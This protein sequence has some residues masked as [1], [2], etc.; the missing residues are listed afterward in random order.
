MDKLQAVRQW[1]KDHDIPFLR[2]DWG[3]RAETGESDHQTQATDVVGRVPWGRREVLMSSIPGQLWWWEDKK[4]PWL[5]VPH[6]DWEE[7]LETFVRPYLPLLVEA[8]TRV[9]EQWMYDRMTYQEI[10]DVERITREAV[11]RR[12][13]RGLQDLTRVIA[14]DDPS[15]TPPRDR[16]RRDLKEEFAAAE[17][18]FNRYLDGRA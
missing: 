16:R 12:L 5:N 13:K 7:V 8:S 17:R 3:P 9:L 14:A 11:R 15:F 10:A 4:P 18:V 6:T 1:Y 2:E